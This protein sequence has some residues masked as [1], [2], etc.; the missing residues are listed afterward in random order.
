MYFLLRVRTQRKTKDFSDTYIL[1]VYLSPLNNRNKLLQKTRAFSEFLH[2]LIPF[3][4]S[5]EH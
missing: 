2:K 5:K 3:S 1:Q 4:G